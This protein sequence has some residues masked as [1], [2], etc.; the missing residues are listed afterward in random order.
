MERRT[1]D[2]WE[3][4]HATIAVTDPPRDLRAGMIA[5]VRITIT[6]GRARAVPLAAG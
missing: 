6:D 3:Y 2:G 4:L 5:V 1:A